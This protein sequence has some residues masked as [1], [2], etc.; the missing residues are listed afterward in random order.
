MRR[1]R[2]CATA[3]GPFPID[4]SHAKLQAVIYSGVAQRLV[5]L[6]MHDSVNVQTAALRVVGNLVAGDESQA[7]VVLGFG[8]LS[9]LCTLLSHP[10]KSIRK[11]SCWAISNITA[12]T[13]DQI[14]SVI[15][16]QI[17]PPLLSILKNEES[18]VQKEAAWVSEC[19]RMNTSWPMVL[20]QNV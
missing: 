6:L 18:A 11:E 10:K 8:V 15:D 9:K 19:R 7:Q 2:C 16:A 1:L 20:S 3:L 13:P 5:E 4:C 17:I 12:G 14:D